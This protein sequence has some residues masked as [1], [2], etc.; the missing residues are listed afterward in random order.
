MIFQ[1]LIIFLPWRIR[2]W[3]LI[4]L[5]R[6]ELHPSSKIGKSII[7]AK[8]VKLE[9]RASIGCGTYCKRIDYLHIGENSN[10][11][12][13]NIITGWSA[14]SKNVI[15]FKHIPNRKCELV[16][17]AQSG[18]TSRHYFDCTAGIYIG[19]YVQIAGHGTT[20]LTHSIDLINAR[21]DAAPIHIG[22]YCFI[23]IKSTI[24]KGVNITNKVIVGAC[25]LVTKNL[26]DENALY[27]GNP[28]K[29]IKHVESCAFFSRTKGFI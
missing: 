27:G 20:L 16:I 29:L 8:R 4:K 23:G 6:F 7:L 21:Q 12:N 13:F 22:D 10:I 18:I 14:E 15:H 17:G 26:M 2:R 3:L 11:G 19:N 28:A 25:S 1:L 5:C 24:L 9:A